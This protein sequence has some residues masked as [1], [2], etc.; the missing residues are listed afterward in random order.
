[1]WTSNEECDS[2]NKKKFEFTIQGQCVAD[3]S[4][5]SVEMKAGK[6]DIN[7][8]LG[9]GTCKRSATY[10]GPYACAAKTLPIAEYLAK[11]AP[12]FGVIFIIVG[13]IMCF[14]GSKFLFQIVGLLIGLVTAAIVFSATYTMF[15]PT[16]IE[17]GPLIGVIILCIVLGGIV[18]F[19]S[20]KFTKNWATQILSTFGGVV[21]FLMIGKTF[22][23]KNGLYNVLIGVAGA[24]FG[25]FIGNKFEH[26]I[27]AV[28][29]ALIG[30]FLIMR[31]VGCYAPGYPNE[32]GDSMPNPKENFEVYLYLGGFVIF[33]VVGSIFQM[34]KF[35]DEIEKDDDFMKSESE[36]RTCGCC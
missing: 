16:N 35:R 27:K 14:L 9:K 34:K 20:Y 1:V 28:A 25:F 24:G 21:V 22:Q 6:F 5:I 18:S 11:I 36:G 19:F 3:D 30:S 8:E 13:L 33:T 23:L 4:T 2:A 31:G 17:F 26:L 12:F 10:K 32:I 15:L 29:T 7:P